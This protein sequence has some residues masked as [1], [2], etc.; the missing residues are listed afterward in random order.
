MSV[1]ISDLV[2][3]GS[4]NMPEA[5][6]ATIGGAIDFS[7]RVEFNGTSLTPTQFDVVSSSAAD[8]ATLCKISYRDATGVI[9]AP[10][11]VTLT[12]QT[13]AVLTTVAAE[14]LLAG[15]ITGGAIAG[16]TNPGGTAA[17]GDVAVIAHTLP[18]SAHTAQ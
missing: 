18:I 16:L 13:K 3:Y 4:A 8:T 1:L 9:Q 7:K 10:A 11:A 5:D 6:S 14:R 2:L 17:V 15:V 12:G